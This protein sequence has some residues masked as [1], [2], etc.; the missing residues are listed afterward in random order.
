MRSNISVLTSWAVAGLALCL[1]SWSAQART[2]EVGP[3]RA[4]DKP[5]AAAKQA[6][7]GDTIKIADGEYYDCIAMGT[8]NVIIEGSGPNTILTDVACQ[9]KA[10]LVLSGADVTV[11]NLTLTR[12]RVPDGNGAGIRSEG[13]SLLVE[14][15]Q[16]INNQN[17]IL[18]G[19]PDSTIIVRDSLFDRNGVCQ[20]SCSHGI[21]VGH[22]ALLRVERTRFIGTKQGH[23][24]KSRAART[25]VIDC[26]I[27]DGPEGTA[28]YEIELPNGGALLARGNTIEKGPKAENHTAAISIGAEGV[29]QP[30][31][32]VVVENN[33]FRNDGAYPTF[34]VNNITAAEAVLRNNHL[35][36]QARPL[37]GDGTSQ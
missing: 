19:T 17:G 14:H 12:A 4:F 20:N 11:R 5:S 35:S 3:G 34:L 15:V 1:V 24:I 28:S 22:S 33:T 6:A 29:T 13:A 2:L 18:S 21:Y 27:E 25:E 32:D 23:H 16:F 8:S 36:G 7:P 10:L 37:Q 9:G 26:D 30:T 31:R